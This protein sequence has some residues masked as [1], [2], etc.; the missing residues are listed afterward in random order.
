MAVEPGNTRML[1]FVAAL[2]IILPVTSVGAVVLLMVKPANKAAAGNEPILLISIPATVLLITLPPVLA[3]LMP[4]IKEVL[5]VAAVAVIMLIAPLLLTL[6]TT[7]P[8]PAMAPPIFMPSPLVS[9]PVNTREPG[10]VGLE[11]TDMP[12]MVFPLMLD[13][14]V[15]LVVVNK[16]PWYDRLP[17]VDE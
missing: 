9:M 4:F 14:G 8:S 7:L 17:A 2:P 16:I 13:A 11:E 10:A 6:P 5:A 15:P 1:L 12:A 3:Q